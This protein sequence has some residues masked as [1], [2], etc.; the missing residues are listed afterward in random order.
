MRKLALFVLGF[1]A[2]I[3]LSQYFL[4]ETA[5]LIAAAVSVVIALLSFFVK[6]KP[7]VMVRIIAFGMAVGALWNFAYDH[8]YFDHAE[9][10]DGYNGEVSAVAV[11]Y[12]T[13]TD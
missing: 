1:T 13:D 9:T 6:K 11:D 12:P 4:G 8:F 5:Q 10:L 2:A 3:L 7:A